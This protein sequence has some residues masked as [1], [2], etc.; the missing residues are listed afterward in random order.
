MGGVQGEASRR[1]AMFGTLNNGRELRAT[2][3]ALMRIYRLDKALGA[4]AVQLALAAACFAQDPAATSENAGIAVFPAAFFAA[5][6]PVNAL[7]LVNRTPGFAFDRGNQRMRG[8]ESAAGNVLVDGRWPTIKANTLSEVLE[9][10]PFAVIERVELIR[11]EAADFDMMGRQVVLNIVRRK[12]GAATLTGEAAVRKYTDNDRDIGGSARVEYARKAGRF[13]L[14]GGL[15]YKSEQ[16][17]FG[18]GEGPYTLKSE[19]SETLLSGWFDRDDWQ[20]SVQATANG[21]YVAGGIDIGVNLIAKSTSLVLDQF[22]DYETPEGAPQREIVDIER[23]TDVLEFGSDMTFTLA[24]ERRLNAKLLGRTQSQDSDALLRAGTRETFAD[25]EFDSSETTARA[26]FRWD[27]S[28]PLSL[29]LGGEAAFNALDSFVELDVGGA[30]LELPNDS[31]RVEETRY[32]AFARAIVR[33][34]AKLSLEGGVAFEKSTL[35]QSGDANLTKRFDF[36]RPRFAAAWSVNASTDIRLR[37]EKVVGQLDFNA[38][39]ASPSLESG[40]FSA[41]NAGLEPQESIEYELQLERRFWDEAS[42]ILSYTRY[43]RGNSLD[44]ILIGS[45]FDAL[46]NAGKATRHRRVM[47][48]NLPL[49]RLGWAGATYRMRA[50]HFDSEIADPFTGASRVMTG[51]HS[52]VGF[53]GFTW[54]LPRWNSVFGIDGFLGYEDRQYR[55]SEVRIE[56]ELPLPMS[57][58]WDRTLPNGATLRIGIENVRQPGRIRLRELYEEGRS[59]GALSAVERRKTR[60]APHLLLRVRMRF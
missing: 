10:I 35:K 29:E 7:D 53:F 45:G 33:A 15:V 12:G 3:N 8:L 37:V 48:L 41:G 16:A 21:S 31:I 42:V 58:W 40:I 26:L 34:G 44:Y 50:I 38:F 9:S 60:Q 59:G 5:G 1:Q 4:L 39:A 51:R 30:R 18:V 56:R 36:A 23:K 32:E 43:R 46:G 19:E 47:N 28:A 27:L 2:G 57:I 22:G 17:M 52:L 49:D 14:D 24:P 20:R 55:I 54:E 25:S 13:D 11:A 6:E